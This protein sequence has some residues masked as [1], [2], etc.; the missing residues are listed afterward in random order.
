M[1]SINRKTTANKSRGATRGVLVFLVVAVCSLVGISYSVFGV[2]VPPDKIGVRINYFDLGFLK[3]GYAERGLEPGLHLRIP[4][5]TEIKLIPRNFQIIGLAEEKYPADLDLTT[6]EV[7]T[8]DGPTVNTDVSLVV[9]YFEQSLPEHGGPAQ[10]LTYFQSEQSRQLL[11]IAQIAQDG[12]RKNLSSLSTSDFYNPELREAGVL[13]AQQLIDQ[14]VM[15]HGVGIWGV[16]IGRYRYADEEIDN[17]IFAKNIQ[18][19]TEKLRASQTKLAEASAQVNKIIEFWNQ[20]VRDKQIEGENYARLKSAEARFIEET[21]ESDGVALRQIAIADIS[22]KK[23]KLLADGEA[24][25]LLVA[26]ELVPLLR[27]FKG[28]V[29]SSIDPYDLNSWVRKLTGKTGV[30]EQ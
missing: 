5:V 11:K 9:R 20:K 4:G 16:L 26:R 27:T 14:E 23:S 17:Q 2:V 15:I 28:G 1:L 29:V 18:T 12:I 19:Q 8:T 7:R 22:G 13:S 10:I 6:L 21:K 3:S 25:E 30:I 24:G